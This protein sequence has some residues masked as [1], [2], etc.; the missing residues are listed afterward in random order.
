MY[1]IKIVQIIKVT[2]LKIFINFISK[3]IP[4]VKMYKHTQILTIRYLWSFV[5]PLDVKKLLFL[6]I[7]R[8]QE[9]RPRP[10]INKFIL[11]IQYILYSRKR[12]LTI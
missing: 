10:N 5:W 6:S 9:V 1:R 2:C 8:I 12:K 7:H 11:H 3:I 4:K